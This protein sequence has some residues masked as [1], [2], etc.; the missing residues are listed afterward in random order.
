MAATAAAHRSCDVLVIGGGPA[1]AAAAT[2]LAVQGLDVVIVEKDRH[3]RFHIGESLLPQSLPLLE[4]LGA[5]D[6]VRRIGV[7]KAAAEFISEDGAIETVFEFRRAL[8]GGPPGAFQVRRSEFDEILFARAIEAGATALQQTTASVRSLD[9]DGAVV[10]TRD[11]DGQLTEWRARFLV[12]ASGRSTVTAKLLAQK[13]PDPHNTSAAI[14]G[15]FRGV[16]RANGARAGNIRIHLTRPGWMWQIPLREDIT[17]IGLVAPGAYMEAREG[18]IEA[19][20]ATHCAR[21]PHVAAA[22]RPAGRVGPLRA[23]GNFS[24]RASEAAGP[25][26]VKVGDAYG[27]V[28][29][30]FSTGVHLALVSA[31][32]AAH[33]VRLVLDSPD[34]RARHLARYDRGLRRRLA[35]VSWFIYRIQDPAFRHMMVHPRDVLGMERAVISLLAGDFRRDPRLRLRVAMFKAT[36]YMVDRLG[37]ANEGETIG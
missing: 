13:H 22:L 31:R 25:S 2:H 12:D 9:A 1:G 29:P 24:Y 11:A 4:E 16:P 8:L 30:I 36:R 34:R 33:T 5:L 14:F 35:F 27:F 10:E 26:H 17:S 6:A 23:T 19:F 18:G 20:F 15:H 28:D 37:R 7:P 3:P 21:H 32:E